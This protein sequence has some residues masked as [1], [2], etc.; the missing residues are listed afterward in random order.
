MDREAEKK[1]FNRAWSYLNYQPTAKW[2]ALAAAA[3]TGVIYVLLLV[4]LWLFADLVVYR[5][6]I[7]SYENLAPVEQ[8]AFHER[9]GAEGPRPSL[10]LLGLDPAPFEA[11]QD[12]AGNAVYTPDQLAFLWRAHVVRALFERVGGGAAALVIPP[13]RELP[14]HEQQFVQGRWA[15]L[16]QNGQAVPLLTE[17]LSP[18]NEDNAGR[19][20]AAAWDNLNPD[21]CETLWRALLIKQ[22]RDRGDAAGERAAR[23]LQRGL[24]QEIDYLNAVRRGDEAVQPALDER[25]LSDRGILGLVVRSDLRGGVAP[26]LPGAVARVSWTWR[27]RPYLVF[28]LAVAVALAVL[29][30]LAAFLMRE[31]AGRA[32]VEAATR[33]RRAVY[34]H[35]FRLGTLAFRAL[36]PSEAVTVFTRH[37][38]AVHD[39]LYAWVTVYFRAP[40][41]FALLLIFALVVNPELALAFLLFALLVWLIGGQ[42]AVYYRRS[43]R[44]AT[45][46]A[47]ERLAAIRESLMLMRLVKIYMMELFN[48]SRVERQLAR[49]AAAQRQRYRGEAFYHPLLYFL[50]ALAAI[51]LLFVAGLLVLPGSLGVPGFIALVTALVSLYWPVQAWLE[52]RRFLRR[53]KEAAV[54]LFQFL[55]RPGEVG[56]VVGAEFLPPMTKQLEFDAV[57]LR[58]PGTGRPLLQNVTFT[59]PAGQRAG[60]VGPEDLEKHALVYLIPRLLDP[61]SGEIRIDDHNLRW[62]TLDSLRAQIATVLLHNLVFHDTVANN[63]S[64]GDPAYTL[65]QVIEA[66]KIAHAH[67]FI[68][69]LPQGYETPI[70][71]MG[72]ALTVGEQFRIGLARAIL[73]DPAILIIEEPTAPLD[74]DT[75]SLLDD[76][77]ARFL[78]GRTAIF[79]PHRISTI[80][81]CDQVFLLHRGRIEAAGTHKELLAH[82]DLYRH[83]HYLEFSEMAELV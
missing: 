5:G 54:I 41:T 36:G 6:Q 42:V 10:E 76:T 25:G 56:Q 19:L 22:F 47:A 27:D 64:C 60:I 67:H 70:G 4:V 46:Q 66:A 78:P 38:E 14:P 31:M 35:T 45:N 16:H 3:A 77:F 7:S 26:Y 13:Y 74:E 39:A 2:I 1:A 17:H 48:Q 15:E 53:G 79:L 32:T 18:L 8:K 73:R 81:S 57:S 55:D 62:V 12:Q 44:E 71:E 52:N 65:P 29:W 68:Q 75:K 23:A 82:N 30:A 72:H 9:L 51:L 24:V 69:K 50:G 61:N 43:G 49:L 63:I 80:K 21:E 33:L 40:V 20:A 28:L 83:L 59:I 37:V 58:E 11:A 34:H